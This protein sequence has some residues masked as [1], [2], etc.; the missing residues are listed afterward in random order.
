MSTDVWYLLGGKAVWNTTREEL[1]LKENVP[2]A[3]TQTTRTAATGFE[4]ECALNG[5]SKSR[6]RNENVEECTAEVEVQKSRSVPGCY[7][8]RRVSRVHIDASWSIPSASYPTGNMEARRSSLCCVRKSCLHWHAT[9]PDVWWSLK[10]F[11]GRGL[12]GTV[13]E[14]WQGTVESS[15]AAERAV[16]GCYIIDGCL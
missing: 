3:P 4:R 15:N 9:V 7:R 8:G 13:V 2:M 1:V 5:G 14:Q 11:L 10:G 6:S 16:I 12:A